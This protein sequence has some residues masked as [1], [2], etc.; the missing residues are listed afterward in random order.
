VQQYV[1]VNGRH[2]PVQ[3][4]TV[5]AAG[6]DTPYGLKALQDECAALRS[7]AEGG[8]NTALNT[9][10]LKVA[11]LVAGGE[12]TEATAL[13]ALQQAARAAGLDDAEIR[14]TLHSGWQAGLQHPRTAPEQEARRVAPPAAPAVPAVPATPEERERHDCD[15]VSD[16]MQRLADARAANRITQGWQHRGIVLPEYPA[17]THA[18]DGVS[19]WC[20]LTGGTGVG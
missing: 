18:L 17:L 4:P 1:V 5:R 13:P 11:S 12:L 6:G 2:I 3:R 10:A 20:L 7:T 8:R 19:G 16:V 15:R 14:G 9:A